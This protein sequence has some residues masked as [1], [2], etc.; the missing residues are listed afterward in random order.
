LLGGQRLTRGDEAKE[1]SQRCQATVSSVN[2]GP[3][4]L[5]NVLQEGEDFRAG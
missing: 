1:T 2:T 5:L 3:A 4:F